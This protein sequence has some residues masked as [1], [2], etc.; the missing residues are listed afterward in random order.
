MAVTVA[1]RVCLFLTN[2]VGIDPQERYSTQPR[3]LEQRA[4]DALGS[5]EIYLEDEPTVPR[6]IWRYTPGP[7]RIIRYLV[8]VLPLPVWIS[9]YNF[10]WLFEDMIA[11]TGAQPVNY[12]ETWS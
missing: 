10:R 11:G 8:G 6:Y 12:Y 3:D 9:R 1:S 5:A 2:A 7:R 4:R